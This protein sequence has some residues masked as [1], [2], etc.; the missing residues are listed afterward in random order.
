M[1]TKEFQ[2]ALMVS[3]SVLVGM[4]V[5]H[6]G[7]MAMRS[8]IARNM[9]YMK[10]WNMAIIA[11]ILTLVVNRTMLKGPVGKVLGFASK[12][13]GAPGLVLVSAKNSRN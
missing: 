12:V 7:C 8:Q 11:F 4:Y 13:P 3:F 1:S 2:N 5:F 10:P 6:L 9:W